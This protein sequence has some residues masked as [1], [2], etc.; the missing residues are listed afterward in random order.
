MARSVK[1]VLINHRGVFFATMSAI[2]WAINNLVVH[3]VTKS[4]SS[5]FVA[6][7]SSLS[8][9]FAPFFIRWEN[10][11]DYDCTDMI[12]V[13]LT[14]LFESG[15]MYLCI[16]SLSLTSIGNVAS[17]NFSKTI[18]CAVM[19]KIFLNEDIFLIDAIL[20]LAN[21]GGLL[22]IAKP[23]LLFGTVFEGDDGDSDQNV[24]GAIAAFV[25]AIGA[26]ATF[27]LARI[28]VERGSYDP[29]VI[30]L[31]KSMIGYGLFSLELSVDRS[32]F[33]DH[34]SDAT[35]CFHFALACSSGVG[36]CVLAYLALQTEGASTVAVLATLQVGI[37]Y[38]LQVMFTDEGL[39]L[40]S[41]VGAVLILLAPFWYGI[42]SILKCNH[43]D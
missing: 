37:A 20:L 16:W 27:I 21:I 11:H 22:C 40:L 23:S 1:S 9:I 8:Y 41:M 24:I 43:I 28:L 12:T 34:S 25:G 38:F 7:V 42:R 10:A 4:V 2:L 30:F 39:N 15:S 13:L 6:F 36:A 5:W 3:I 29:F 35:V 33:K 17:I 19:S 31:V 18:L 32:T 14:G 26:A